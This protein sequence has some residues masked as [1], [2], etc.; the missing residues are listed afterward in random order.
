MRSRILKSIFPFHFLLLFAALLY[1]SVAAAGELEQQNSQ[2]NGVSI[3]VKPV[4]V[5][6]ANW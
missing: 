4:D 2:A 6:A 5:S 1:G 3:S